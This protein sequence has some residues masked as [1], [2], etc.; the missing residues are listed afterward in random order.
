LKREYINRMNVL[1]NHLNVV[2]AKKYEDKIDNQ[3]TAKQVL[4][5]ELIK[6]GIKSTK[7]LAQHLEISASAVS[8]LLNKLEDKGYIKRE[9]N[10]EN[11]RETLLCLDVQAE[12][13]FN[14]LLQLE[15]EIN[16]TVYEKLSVEDL[17]EL[18]R[19]LEKLN[20]LIELEG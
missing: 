12:R 4:V 13:Y 5:L 6:S 17:K 2:L 11:R 1:Q 14:S 16:E 8:Q 18:L 7:E 3:L 10:K 19:I 20:D 9:L 15:N